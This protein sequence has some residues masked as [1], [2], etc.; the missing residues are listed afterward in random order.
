MAVIAMPSPANW[1]RRQWIP[2]A[3]N[4]V[5]R[6]GWTGKRTVVRMPGAALWRVSASLMPISTAMAAEPWEAWLAALE[7]SA[8]HFYMPI[9][10]NQTAAANPTVGTGGTAQGN[11]TAP[12]TGMP[13]SATYLRAGQ[14]MTFYLPSGARQLVILTAPLVANGSGNGTATF[15]GAVREAL[16]AGGAI[17]ARN[18][19]CEMAMTNDDSGWDEDEGVFGLSFDAEEAF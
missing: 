8:N 18:P 14:K 5:N 3:K 17:E 6:S 9:G 1:T 7:G 4:Q 12:V 16:T 11:D 15:R 2:P 19:F 10:C 13:A